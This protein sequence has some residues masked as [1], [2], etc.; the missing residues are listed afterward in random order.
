[1][2]EARLALIPAVPQ[3]NPEVL[4]P[5]GP[6]QPE[7]VPVNIHRLRRLLKSHNLRLVKDRSKGSFPKRYQL[8]SL[9]VVAGE[10]FDLTLEQV[11]A[12]RS[13]LDGGR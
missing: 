2:S 4:P 6:P 13:R 10:N 3:L 12:I 7:P 9:T 11:S 5:L 8:Q 1:M